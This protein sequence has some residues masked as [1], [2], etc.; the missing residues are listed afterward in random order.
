MTFTLIILTVT[1]LAA[2][3]IAVDLLRPGAARSLQTHA[4]G[5][6][7]PQVSGSYDP[8]SRLLDKEDFAA[9]AEHADLADR[10]R[11]SRDATMR[12]YL[13]QIRG[14]FLQVWDVCRLL[15]P[16]S[17]DPAFASRLT[18]QYWS[19][20]VAY[21]SVYAQCLLPAMMPASSAADRLVSALSDLREQ[22]RDLLAAS[23][24]ALAAPSAA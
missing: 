24:S 1:F 5:E 7:N 13:R 21:V 10:L 15:A 4:G 12:L 9:V 14:E 20:H 22:A 6:G 16:I 2:V 8:V 18:R 19:F 23:D 3:W 11:N 17:P